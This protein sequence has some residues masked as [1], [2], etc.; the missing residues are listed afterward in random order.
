[1]AL[2]KKKFSM[3]A[4]SA[5]LFVVVMLSSIVYSSWSFILLFAVV[6]FIALRE[7]S[8]LLERIYK[9]SFLGKDRFAYYVAGFCAYI[10]LALF[11]LKAC[12]FNY[13]ILQMPPLFYF[14]G[15]FIGMLFMLLISKDKK[16]K[17]LITGI[18]Y[19]ALPLA[20]LHHLRLQSLMIPLFLIGSIWI[21]DT[22]A[23]IGGSFLGKTPLAPSISPNKTIEGTAI[24]ILFA[25]GFAFIWSTQFTQ[26]KLVDYFIL[27][28]I[29]SSLGGVGDL[30]ESRL[31]RWANVKDSGQLMPG[32]GGALDRFDSLIFAS[33][34]AF[35]YAFF[36]MDCQFWEFF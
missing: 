35:I 14:L 1:M 16:A 33:S 28:F 30:I 23:Y 13:T 34:F 36:F 6:Q 5:L 8:F 32:H 12:S 2:D 11:P 17:M 18:G 20:L 4:L 7:Y 25:L 26:Y 15:I 24:G 29:G 31:K 27:A 3:R 19:I 22:M 21:N 10:F 9:T